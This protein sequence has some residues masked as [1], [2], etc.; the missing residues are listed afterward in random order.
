MAI[1][2]GIIRKMTGSAGQLTFK[3]LN[4][5]T[6]VSEKVS[7]VK[8]T[9]TAAQQRQRMKWVNIIRM[10]AGIAPLLKNGFEKK[11]ATQSDYNIF[12]RLNNNVSPIYLTKEE[13]D[14]GAC[15]A[16]PYQ[17]TQGSLPA[18]VTSGQGDETKTDIR[19]GTLLISAETT[20]ADFARAVVDHNAD[21]D[22]GDQISFYDIL[23]RVNAETQ[24]P[25]CQFKASYVVLEKDSQAK[26][27]ALVSPAG[28]ASVSNGQDSY[29]LGHG[30]A[31]GDGVFAWVHSRYDN[32]KTKVST[33]FLVDNNTLAPDY[34]DDKAYTLAC[35]S[36]GGSN[37]AFLTPDAGTAPGASTGGSN[38]DEG[39]GSTVTQHVLTL[40][41]SP[42]GGGSVTGAGTY[43]H[44]A[45][46]T[47]KATANS[48]YT[49]TG[50][51][52]SDT[53]AERTITLT[54]DKSLTASFQSSSSGG[55]DDS[56]SPFKP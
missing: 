17:L 49:F 19:L 41:A 20:V 54:A 9:R 46:V 11:G 29:L 8:N 6:I 31:E 21:Y 2:K 16:A 3:R 39:S 23:Q 10:Y 47:I 25:Y 53:H 5:Q 12:V 18:I 28:F 22:Y 37:T 14:G 32:G 33:Q 13:A 45:Q 42:S 56:D 24:I 15:I 48:G 4:G 43:E 30:A 35:K 26:L 36:Y 44:G 38:G 51:S 27:L 1:L 52:D 55:E 50:W 34:R 7:N 40:T